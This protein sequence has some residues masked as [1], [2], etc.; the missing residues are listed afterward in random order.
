MIGYYIAA[1]S[2]ILYYIMIKIQSK[3]K[4]ND[5]TLLKSNHSHLPGL[6]CGCGGC[7][8]LAST[9]SRQLGDF[10]AELSGYRV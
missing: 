3:P 4:H 1:Y 6:G 10:L 5:M 2:I 8:L 9:K 7:D